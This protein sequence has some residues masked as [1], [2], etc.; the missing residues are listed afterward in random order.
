MAN[1][2][3]QASST[4]SSGSGSGGGTATPLLG[5]VWTIVFALIVLAAFGV[6]FVYATNRLSSL[7]ETHWSRL[8]YLY[9]GIEA[10]AF[11]VIGAIFGTT[12]QRQATDQANTRADAHAEQAKTER[13]RANANQEAGANGRALAK[14]IKGEARNAP[15]ASQLATMGVDTAIAPTTPAEAIAA[16]LQR[17][18]FVAQELFPEA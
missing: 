4:G 17:L 5:R 6:I 8:V 15:V 13:A 12:I 18:S 7:D 9:G 1:K 3:G 14:M 2:E 10:I 16:H 11:G